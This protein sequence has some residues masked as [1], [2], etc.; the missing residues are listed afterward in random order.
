[1]KVFDSTTTYTVFD[2]NT[3]VVFRYNVPAAELTATLRECEEEG[4]KPTFS[5]D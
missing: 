4:F 5:K 3:G 1:M 2:D